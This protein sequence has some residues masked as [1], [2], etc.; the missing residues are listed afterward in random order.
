MLQYQ[1]LQLIA[2]YSDESLQG[3]YRQA[4]T[5]SNDAIG[6]TGTTGIIQ[7]N[8][9]YDADIKGMVEHSTF[10]DWAQSQ[11]KASQVKYSRT[12]V[13]YSHT[14]V[15]V[16]MGD[17]SELY[18]DDEPDGF[19]DG[20]TDPRDLGSVRWLVVVADM[21]SLSTDQLYRVLYTKK[22]VKRASPKL[23]KPATA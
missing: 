13:M 23:R 19:G 15:V 17:L 4:R 7:Q 5:L 3:I 16:A 11:N 20:D 14:A 9:F 22:Q 2:T 10:L 8:A 12:S 1:L 18:D 21:L 6:P